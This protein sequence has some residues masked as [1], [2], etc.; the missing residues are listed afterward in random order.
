MKM[1][2]LVAGWFIL[3]WF[4]IPALTGRSASPKSTEKAA[5]DEG[6]TTADAL[7]SAFEKNPDAARKKFLTRTKEGKLAVNRLTVFG[8]V[9][10]VKDH[11]IIVETNSKVAVVLRAKNITNHPNRALKDDAPGRVIPERKMVF[12]SGHVSAFDGKTVVVECEKA[13]LFE[14]LKL[15]DDLDPFLPHG[16][17]PQKKSPAGML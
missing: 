10:H 15:R 2:C 1:K 11:D 5:P 16:D 14:E 3:F 6:L 4:G 12:A 13:A 17:L 7:A 9:H 8:V